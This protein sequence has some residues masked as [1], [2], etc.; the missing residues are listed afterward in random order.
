MQNGKHTSRDQF[1][2]KILIEKTLRLHDEVYVLHDVNVIINN[3]I[4][5]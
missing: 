1:I 4:N 2:S 3:L 5:F